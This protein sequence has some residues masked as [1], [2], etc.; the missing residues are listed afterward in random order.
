MNGQLRNRSPWW[1]RDAHIHQL[2][3]YITAYRTESRKW[4]TG[5]KKEE[6]GLINTPTLMQSKIQALPL[7]TIEIATKCCKICFLQVIRKKAQFPPVPDATLECQ[8]WPGIKLSAMGVSRSTK[9]WELAET[10]LPCTICILKVKLQEWMWFYSIGARSNDDR[11]HQHIHNQDRR[12]W[13]S[14]RPQRTA[15]F[16]HWQVTQ[17]KKTIKITDK[18]WNE[19]LAYLSAHT[20]Y[21]CKISPPPPPPPI[22]LGE[23]GCVRKWILENNFNEI[24]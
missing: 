4:I 1:K 14:S 13:W 11:P 2:S 7:H 6:T 15:C 18:C 16:P 20:V 24:F 3:H 10:G 12:G 17:E 23:Y 9:E 22:T 19:S 8:A 5:F 21:P